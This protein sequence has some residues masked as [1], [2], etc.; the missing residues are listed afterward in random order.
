MEKENEF[1]EGLRDAIPVCLGYLAV[2]FAFGIQAAEAGLSVFQASLMSLTNVTSAGQFSSLDLI[3]TNAT[4]AEMALLQLVVNIRYMLMSTALSQKFS[5]K[6][7]TLSR[8]LVAYGVT[9][10]IFGLS[11]T[12]K[13]RLK[14]AYSYGLIICSVF[15]WVLGTFLGAFAGQIMPQ[16]LISALGLAIY[17]MFLAII[18]PEASE[19]GAVMAVVIGAMVMSTVFTYAPVLSSISSGFRIIIVT[20]VIAAAAA[21]FAPRTEEDTADA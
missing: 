2:S 13:G 5:S 18:I 10:E 8:C 3:A 9:D 7:G 6:V 11:V 12:R 1:I 20:V 17:G 21:I 19:N 16:R 4:Y 15:G 14:P